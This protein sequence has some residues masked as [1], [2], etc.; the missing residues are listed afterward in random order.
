[1]TL[2]GGRYRL[3]GLLGRGGMGEVYRAVDT[4]GDEAVA[5]KVL[6]A[7]AGQ[8]HA[9]RLRREAGIAASLHDPHIVEVLDT[10]TDTEGGD[11]RL[12]VAMRLVEGADLKRVLGGA[13]MPPPRTL[14][15]L[16]QVAHALDTAHAAGVVHRDV[17]PSN[18]LVGPDDDAFL[19][20]FGIARPLDPEATRMTVTGGY[21]GS[22]DY[23]APEQL[24]GLDVTGAADVYSLACVLY[25]CLTGQ[26]PFPAADPAAKLAAQLNTVPAAAST[27][28]PAVPPALDLVVATGMDKDPRRRYATA[29]QLLAAAQAA[30]HQSEDHTTPAVVLPHGDPALPGQQVIMRAIVTTAARRNGDPTTPADQSGAICPYPGLRS[31]AFGDAGWFF[32]RDNETSDLLVRLSGQLGTGGPLVVV[33]ASGSGKSSLLVAGLLPALDTAAHDTERARWPRVVLT[34]GDRPIDTLAARLAGVIQVDPGALATTIRHDPAR[35]GHLLRTAAERVAADGA[36]LVI[37]IDQFEQLF[38]DG[39]SGQERVAFATA[40]AHAW[41][42]LVIIA[43]RAD[44][45]PDCIALEPL[46]TALD[47]PFV[48]G[49]LGAAALREVIT[50]PAASA[51][52]VLEDG[53]ADRLIADVGARDGSGFA[54]GALPR[55]AH[56]LRATWQNRWGNVLTLRGYQATGGVDR[57]VAVTADQLFGGLHPHHQDVLRATLLR[58]VRVLPDGGLTRRTAARGELDER[59]VA[60]LVDARLVTA[61]DDGVRL[62]HDAL[63]TAWPRL[64]AWADAERQDLLLRQRL[65][66][67]AASWVDSGRDRGDVYRG[68]RLAA[69]LDWAAQHQVTPPQ[70]EFLRASERE[71]R[72]GTRRLRT[73]IAALAVLLVAS[74]AASVV[75][76]YQ[77]NVADDRLAEAESRRLATLAEQTADTWPRQSQL[78]A[79]AAWRRAQTRQAREALL[80][81]ENQRLDTILSGHK[82]P[83]VAVAFSPDGDRLVSG[84]VDGTVRVWDMATRKGRVLFET[85]EAINA[86]EFSPDGSRLAV[87]STDETLYLLNAESGDVRQRIDH[88]APVVAVAFSPDGRTVVSSNGTP[89]LWDV[90]SGRRLGQP[91]AGHDDIVTSVVFTADGSRI[92]TSGPDATIRIWDVATQTSTRTIATVGPC[93]FL[94]YDPEHDEVA[95]RD[96]SAISR[97]DLATGERVGKPLSGH[98][99]TIGELA[100]GM[101]GQ[102]LASTSED[103]TVRL[104][105]LATGQQIG[106]PMRASEDDTFGVAFSPDNKVLAVASGDGNIVLWRPGLPAS[107]GRTAFSDISPDGSVVAFGDTEGTVTTWDTTTSEPKGPPLVCEDGSSRPP[108]FAPDGERIAVPCADGLAIWTLG[109]DEV[110]RYEDVSASPV[111][112]SPD[113]DTIAAFDDR[114]GDGGMLVLLDVDTGKTRDVWEA[115]KDDQ[116]VWSLAFSPGGDRIAAGSLDGR[117]TLWDTES[118][119]QVGE[120]MTGHIDAVQDIAFQPHGNLLATTGWDNTVRLW[121]LTTYRQSGPSL[122]EHTDRPV[123]VSFS[124]DG[125]RFVTAGWD[126]VPLVWDVAGPTVLAALSEPPDIQA[127]Q[128]LSDGT[129]IGTGANGLI[130]R[131][132][133]DPEQALTDVCGRL[134]PLDEDEWRQFA[135]DVD[136]QPQC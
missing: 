110:T 50:L 34:P 48:V 53:L 20:D 36:R 131:W 35:F 85:S 15:L 96:G 59:A 95:C 84:G 126:G 22:L 78:L 120:A 100:Y 132:D 27:Y 94:A 1:V 58:L 38:T 108:V 87:G 71:Q 5:I 72:R 9:D 4:V 2:L 111:R 18:I 69:A 68:A 67:S 42:A 37:I 105:Y 122:T 65:D 97:F 102:L 86:V 16:T 103:R 41:P 23:I 112:F 43:V 40:L 115:E 44:Y 101:D 127:V 64:R 29:G 81:T 116:S 80:A 106:E 128:Y 6:P 8:H 113:G 62:A 133:T 26:V 57:A 54:Q 32:G 30:L 99:N 66:E 12:Y 10:G 88:D 61:D 70:Q 3:E 129:L 60:S 33:G 83:V 90:G 130:A 51:G 92:L 107:A 118:G 75:A 7:A 56:A 93:L 74:L 76:Y 79:A 89:Q 11:T 39:A 21:V 49:P 73:V 77:T 52:L 136:F 47:A 119:E 125:T 46:R 63:L 117:I 98:T 121:D 24:R 135:A 123:T 91:L 17:K 25:E 82:G 114:P 55:L 45:V 124:P 19:T 109:G 31:F 104:W 134:A 13:P 14:A 28:Q